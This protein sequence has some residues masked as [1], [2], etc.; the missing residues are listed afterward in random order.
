MIELDVK[1]YCHNYSD[2]EPHAER[3]YIDGIATCHTVVTCEYAERCEHIENHIKGEMKKG[4][5]NEN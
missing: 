4:L 3:L 1:G 5:K 2:F